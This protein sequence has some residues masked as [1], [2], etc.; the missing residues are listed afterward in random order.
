MRR[1]QGSFL[2]LRW[3]SFRLNFFQRLNFAKKAL[4]CVLAVFLNPPLLW[5]FPKSGFSFGWSKNVRW[6]KSRTLLEEKPGPLPTGKGRISKRVFQEKKAC[7]IFRKTNISHPLIRKRTC[8][9]QRVRNVCFWK[10]W[11]ALFF[12]NMRFEIRPFALTLTS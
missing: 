10:I 7:Q 2:Y 9:Y 8:A 5:Y 12:W 1:I 6:L 3:I 4:Y 11:H